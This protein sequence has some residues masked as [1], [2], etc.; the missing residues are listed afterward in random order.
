[1]LSGL[2]VAAVAPGSIAAELGVEPGDR[3]LAANGKPVRDLIDFTYACAGAALELTV[4][5]K[6]AQ[7]KSWR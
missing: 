4:G 3:V 5:K 1:M 6:T 2:E 7:K